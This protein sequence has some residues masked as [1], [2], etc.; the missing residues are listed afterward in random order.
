MRSPTLD[1]RS[2]QTQVCAV[3][4]EH[5]HSDNWISPQPEDKTV[6]DATF[7]WTLAMQHFAV[8]SAF[9]SSRTN[10][11]RGSRA[12]VLSRTS[13]SEARQRYRIPLSIQ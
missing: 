8:R 5:G 13:L 7:H 3:A 9:F 11:I 1:K 4:D 2:Q 10:R 6:D 12:A